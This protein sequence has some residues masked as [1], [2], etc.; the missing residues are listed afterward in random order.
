[1]PVAA[2]NMASLW[3]LYLYPELKKISGKNLAL[4]N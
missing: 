2:F 3:A 4:K 1:M